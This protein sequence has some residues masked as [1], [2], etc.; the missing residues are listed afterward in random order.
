MPNQA[1]HEN[2]RVLALKPAF[3]AAL[4]LPKPVA[5]T[6][7]RIPV[8]LRN[9]Q[10]FA[11]LGHFPKQTLSFCFFEVFRTELQKVFQLDAGTALPPDTIQRAMPG[12]H[13]CKVFLP[14]NN[15]I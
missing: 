12:Q 13:S 3:I 9:W 1:R 8:N 14:M 2:R 11:S 4:P 5:R 6:T 7:Q 15:P 10:G